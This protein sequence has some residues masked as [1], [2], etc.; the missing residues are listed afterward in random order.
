M[1]YC[2]ITDRISPSR[3][4]GN[5][6]VDSYYTMNWG[7]S[8][9]IEDVIGNAFSRSLFSFLI[10][11]IPSCLVKHCWKKNRYFGTMVRLRQKNLSSRH[12]SA[13][14]P[15]RLQW[16]IVRNF[17]EDIQFVHDVFVRAPYNFCKQTCLS[18]CFLLRG[19][20]T[21]SELS[22]TSLIH[23]RLDITL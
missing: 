9:V 4:C 17:T 19:L 1:C 14:L 20:P 8:I 6:L 3:L 16:R 23:N 2:V 18:N 10:F 12:K 15:S 13:A 22:S 7:F 21:F 5:C 11:I